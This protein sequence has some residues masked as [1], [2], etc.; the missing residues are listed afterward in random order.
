MSSTKSFINTFM[1]AIATLAITSCVPKATEK[2]AACG[3]N[4]AFSSVSRSCYSILEGRTK[5][6]GTTATAAMSEETFQTITLAYTDGNK[7]KAVSCKVSSISS[8]LEMIAPSLADGGLFVKADAVYDA[9][10][11]IAIEL[12]KVADEAAMR[13]SL[14]AAKAS[15]YYST[16]ATH[17][18][19]FKSQANLLIGFGLGVTNNA[20]IMGNYTLGQAGM[21]V[22][23]SAMTDMTNRCECSGG[24]CKTVT[25]PKLN[26]TGAAGFSYTVTDVDG[27][28]SAKAVA[29]TISSLSAL[30]SNLQPIG[31]LSLFTASESVTSIPTNYAVTIPDAGDIVGT[32][33]TSYL[34]KFKIGTGFTRKYGNPIPGSNPSV[35]GYYGETPFGAVYGCMDLYPYTSA[36]NDKTCIYVPTNGDTFDPAVVP[37]PNAFAEMGGV[38]DLT[39]TAKASGTTGNN[40][41]VQLFDLKAAYPNSQIYGLTGTSEAFIR[42]EGNDIKIFINPEVTTYAQVSALITAHSQASKLVTASAGS[43]SLANP[44]SAVS[45][46]GGLDSFD[47]IPYTVNNTKADSINDSAVTVRITSANDIP[48][49]PKTYNGSIFAPVTYV[50]NEELKEETAGPVTLNFKDVD[51]SG[52]FVV[53][54]RFDTLFPTC[55]TGPTEGD[56]TSYFASLGV[57]TNLVLTPGAITC[58]ATTKACTYATTVTPQLNFTGK[59]CLYYTVNDGTATSYV[60]GI[61]IDV[62][63]INDAPLISS[64]NT[65]PIVTVL[66]D[67]ATNEDLAPGLPSYTDIY[68]SPG[69]GV[70][71][72][73][74]LLTVTATSSLTGIIPN[75]ACKNYIPYAG[76]PVNV[77]TPT[78]SGIYYFDKVNFR[79]YVSTG[80]VDATNWKLH[81][82][83]TAY[84][85]CAYDY[86][87][88]G[89]PSVS[90]SAAGKHYLDTTNNRCYVSASTSSSSWSQDKTISNYKVSYVPVQY[91]SSAAPPV[92]ITI[93]VQDN[94]GKVA[95]SGDEDTATDDFLLTV[96]YIN[97][98]PFFISTITTIETNEGGAVQSNAFQ[99]DED[100]GSTVD[101]NAQGVSITSIVTDNASVLP[102]SAI[103][104]FYDSNNNGVEDSGEARTVGA[105]LEDVPA[106]DVK[107][108][109][110]YLKLDPVDGI[111]GNANIT[112]TISDGTFPAT[113]TFSFIVHPIAALHGGWTNI[114]S[115]GIKTDKVGTPVTPAEIQ[116]NFNK[117]EEAK[118]C[119]TATDC[120]GENSPTGTIIPNAAN[121]LYWDSKASRCY[122]STSASQFAWVDFNTSCPVSRTVPENPVNP[123]D[124]CSGGNC[125]G[126]MPATYPLG[127]EVPRV[128]SQYYYN[129]SS[130]TCYVST[131]AEDV[132][133]WKVFVPAKVTLSWKPFIM[134]G[135]GVDSSVQT[136]GWNVYR[137]DAMT[138]YNFKGGHL[139]NTSSDA[140]FTIKDPSIRTFTDTTAVAGRIYYYVVRPVDNIRKF[141]TYTPEMFSEVRVVAAPENYSFVH[142]WMINQEVCNSMNITTTTT[143]SHVDQTK[144][145]RCEYQG[146]GESATYP[147]YYDYG[148]DILVD[149]QELGCAYAPAP[150]CSANGCVGV[151]APTITADLVTDDLYYDRSTGT[152]SRFDSGTST[153]AEMDSAFTITSALATSMKSALNAPLVN[154]GQARAVDICAARASPFFYRK[155]NVT[156]AASLSVKAIL[157]NKKD[158]TAYSSQRLDMTDPEVT[159]MEQGYSL[160]IQSRCNGSS[161]S[162]LETA[163]TDS[164]IPSTSF[165]HSL[166]GT[167]SSNIR[168]LYTGS[169]SGTISKGTSACVSRY[170]IQDLYGNVAEWT[171]D[172]LNCAFDYEPDPIGAPGVMALNHVCT[173][174]GTGAI[175]EYSFNGTKYGFDNVTGPFNDSETGTGLDG[176]SPLDADLTSW[177]FGDMFFTA[178]KFSLPV[179]LPISSNIVSDGITKFS[180]AIPY[181][182]D[183]GPSSGITSNRLHEDGM[184]PNVTSV[185]NNGGV[186][187]FAVGGSYLSG[188]KAGRYTSELIPVAFKRPDVGMRCIIPVMNYTT[189]D[190]QYTYPY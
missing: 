152:C 11:K 170:G 76:S 92:T 48:M 39:I 109:N 23:T 57:S 34:Y 68:V 153:F 56:V 113:T 173:S 5:P 7:D 161:A 16:I 187:G 70:W 162:G 71:E 12:N 6:V 126:S 93:T 156:L 50:Q 155:D 20:T 107:L 106:D 45:L 82:S 188:N 17:L 22:L 47:K 49:V 178:T 91:Q 184:I 110:F 119:G 144:N 163:Y 157:P 103:S 140:N 87:G 2:K 54:A 141:P 69:G 33:A 51:N 89:A 42:V 164:T 101:E 168:S 149:T 9:A 26:K 108:R 97:N 94:G 43:A 28:G 139:K 58:D 52:G 114:A 96:N 177:V 190:T 159:E 37:H 75:V 180:A 30:V 118:N 29:V 111:S 55:A 147:G 72:A 66:A 77:V 8:N 104:I 128:S 148:K 133:Q 64:T 84:P 99:V 32:S 61:N 182:L 83:L 78:A 130:N 129:L 98:P 169:I 112:M 38:G 41:K 138:D 73:D 175:Y 165:M 172:R 121:V 74:Q 100:E 183:I 27:E 18:A 53:V 179:G 142:R 136:A 131:G 186:G 63:P 189:G 95:L 150:K 35:S 86:Y 122:R 65:L 62:K 160:N 120:A 88:Q 1:L 132:D 151:G 21:L 123:A 166:P 10:S 185:R 158:Y 40:L 4:Q 171:S 80:A 81:P 67:T 14:D 85:N 143:P 127:V 90:P 135:S 115:T 134:V 167:F 31:Q 3:V 105:V 44:T 181:L 174:K 176:P 124:Y 24:I 145:F 46:A 59:A 154:I 125:I 25:I 146:P 19:T 15:I 137:R 13:A 36:S 79:C 116:C 102:T 117:K 60:Q